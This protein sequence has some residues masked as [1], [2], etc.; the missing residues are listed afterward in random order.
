M[1]PKLQAL[2]DKIYEEGV[3]KGEDVAAAIVHEAERKAQKILQEAEQEAKAVRERAR[4]ESE[5]LQRNVNSELQLAAEQ[6]L[7][8]LKQQITDLITRKAVSEPLRQAFTDQ[9]FIKHTVADVITHWQQ[10]ERQGLVLRLPA[11]TSEDLSRYLEAKSRELL[12]GSLTVDLDG[13]LTNGF[14]I[15][16][17]DGNYLISF[18][19]RDFEAFFLD[20]L[21]PR[22]RELLFNDH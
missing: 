18:T 21:R 12:D 8:A 3:A 13:K 14:R 4:R 15:G 5:E 17:A 2:L 20:Y 11:N 19:D 7:S 6:S 16:P 9:N 1:E 22:T 10:G